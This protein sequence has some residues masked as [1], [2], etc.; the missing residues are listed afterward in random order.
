MDPFLEGQKRRD[1]HTS[2]LYVTRRRLTEV[3][4]PRYSVDIEQSVYLQQESGDDL[5]QRRLEIH[6][7]ETR[8]LVTVI[9]ILSP[10]NRGRGYHDYL[11]KRDEDL[12][13]AVH[14]VEWDLL[15]GGRRLLAV[16]P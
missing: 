12:A 11:A 4:K 10:T 8:R 16:E 1:F 14:L 3:L 2:A 9:E 7:H 15:R 5:R 6:D 13:Q